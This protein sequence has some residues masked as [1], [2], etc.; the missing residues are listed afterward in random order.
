[1]LPLENPEQHLIPAREPRSA[2]QPP[3]GYYTNSGYAAGPTFAEVFQPV[4]YQ[5]EFVRREEYSKM[6]DPR[7]ARE[8]RSVWDS[9]T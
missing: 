9:L 6:F 5:G 3:S 4:G 1:M 2:L 8:K 7:E